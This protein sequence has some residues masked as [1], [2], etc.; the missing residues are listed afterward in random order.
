MPAID[1]SRGKGTALE[2]PLSNLALVTPSDSE[3]LAFV[4]RAIY[5]G[6]A[7]AVRVTTLGGQT[8]TTPELSEGWHPIRVA[9]VWATGT[10]ASGIMAAW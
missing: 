8:L 3:D 1:D 2:S 6:A 9:R 7:G 5:V 4:T 10:T